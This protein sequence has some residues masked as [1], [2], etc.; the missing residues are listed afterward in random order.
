MINKV[1]YNGILSIGDVKD[2]ECW[3]DYKKSNNN[4]HDNCVI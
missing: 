3:N 2:K 1:I 4:F